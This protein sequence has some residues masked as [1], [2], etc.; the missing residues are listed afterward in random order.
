MKKFN[1]R[2]IL[3]SV[4]S[5]TI[6]ATTIPTSNVYAS[7]LNI[8]EG[9]FNLNA[10]VI[11]E[12]SLAGRADIELDWSDYSFDV[13]GDTV[14]T[15][16]YVARRPVY[17]Q[18][19]STNVK[20][21]GKWEIRGK[22]G[23]QVSVLNIYPDKA[24]SAG[25]K[26]WM[27]TQ[28]ANE[29]VD[30][31]VTT[32]SLTDFNNNPY[33]Y[34]KKNSN[35]SY[36]FDVIVFG[37][38]DSN[39]KVKITSNSSNIIQDFIDAGYG[40]VFG[41]DTIQHTTINLG[42]NNLVQNNLDLIITK[43]D[44]SRWFY[45][46]KI[47]VRKQGSIT[48]YPFDIN[49]RDLK[50]PM[51]HSVGQ[52]PGNTSTGVPNNDEIYMTFEPNYY[53][54]T[55]DGPYFNYNVN[56]GAKGPSPMVS[57]RHNSNPT[58]N[59][60]GSAYL[61]KTNNVAFI[62]C[63]HS[64]G[65]TSNAEQM[66][67]ANLI[68]SIA[69]I[70]HGESSASDQVL[71]DVA[72]TNPSLNTDYTFSSEDSG[73]GFEYRIIAFPQGYDLSKVDKNALQTALSSNVTK[74]NDNVVFSN[75]YTTGELVSKIKGS[76][77][78]ENEKDIASFRYYVDKNSVGARIP[79]VEVDG[80]EDTTDDFYSLKINDKFDYTKH[81]NKIG[82]ITEDDW[83]H[84]VA[85]DRA[86]NASTITDIRVLDAIPK[87]NAYAK[88]VDKQGNIISPGSV[89][90]D[91]DNNGTIE[92]P[93]SENSEQYVGSSFSLK[94]ISNFTYNGD[95]YIYSHSKN[96]E[97]LEINPVIISL[98]VD[99]SKNTVTH[100]YD[101]KL[102]KDIYLVDDRTALANGSKTAYLYTSVT[103]KE[104]ETLDINS[105]KPDLTNAHYTYN[106]WST[107]TG[108]GAIQN[109]PSASSE[110][111]MSSDV[112]NIYIYYKKNTATLNVNVVRDKDGIDGGDT[113][114]LG[115]Y[116]LTGFVGDTLTVT[117]SD[118]R[119]NVAVDLLNC[120]SNN[121]DL[122]TYNK[123]FV[124]DDESGKSDTITLMPRIKDVVYYGIDFENYTLPITTSSSAVNITSDKIINIPKLYETK[125]T[126]DPSKPEHSNG[127][128]VYTAEATYSYDN[129]VW[130]NLVT[131]GASTQSITVNFAN[132]NKVNVGYFKGIRPLA[133]Y[134]ITTKYY[135]VIDNKE[136]H[137]STKSQ[138][139][140]ISD[141]NADISDIVDIF[142]INGIKYD[143]D[144][145]S[146][147]D[148]NRAV[149]F[150][151][152]HYKVLFNGSV[153]KDNI[154][155]I[156]ELSI[157]IPASGAGAYTVE[158]YYRP[159]T[160]VSCT[161][162]VYGYDRTT[163]ISTQNVIFNQL[164]DN[165]E[166]SIPLKTDDEYT[167]D[168]TGGKYNNG[169]V[170]ATANAYD[171]SL[172]ANY[173]PLVYDL[174]VNVINDSKVGTTRD[175]LAYTF[176]NV[177]AKAVTSFKLPIVSGFEF[178]ESKTLNGTD[179]SYLQTD[180]ETVT[181]DP[182]ETEITST[183]TYEIELH[184]GQNAALDLTYVAF[185]KDGRV[186][187]AKPTD[188]THYV[189][190]TVTVNIPE[191][192]NL[193]LQLAYLDGKKYF[194]VAT[195][196]NYNVEITKPSHQLY[197]VYNEKKYT[198]TVENVTGDET[199]YVVGGGEFYK[200]ETAVI[201]A[202]PATGYKFVGWTISP[203]SATIPSL[204][205]IGE[206]SLVMPMENVVAKA[207]FILDTTTDP[208]DNVEPDTSN[209]EIVQPEKPVEPI[210]PIEPVVPTFPE[211]PE[212]PTKPV[213]PSIDDIADLVNDPYYKLIR[214]YSVYVHGYPDGTIQPSESIKRV[215]V[216]AVI[217][218]L[219]GN[220]YVSD[221]KSLERF[222]DVESGT[223]YS[224]AVGFCAD[225]G[226]V[227]GYSDGTIKPN[228]PIS[229]AELAAI[230]AKFVIAKN[231]SAASPSFTDVKA[232]WVKSSIDTLYKNGIIAGY[233]DGTF[234]PNAETKRSEFVVMLN[235]LIKRPTE[236]KQ[237]KTFPDL[238]K[239][240]W[241][242]DDMMNASNGAVVSAD[243]PDYILEN[244]KK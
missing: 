3:A 91:N 107:D 165:K 76:M 230:I 34:L 229:R 41:H 115:T 138:T 187:K 191:V 219:Y 128:G 204:T 163:V 44:K 150:E 194:D 67:L 7:S 43:S 226:V 108:V 177:P 143:I 132:Q 201:S 141:T 240:H 199:G 88:F 239:T 200:G 110:Y 27:T 24:E 49:G 125:V 162:N 118:I 79:P 218:N 101:K 98:N 50:I 31:V 214:E 184:Y 85:Y 167:I 13:N 47:S 215:E 153:V 124:L 45:S 15:D 51:S 16:Y 169:V 75:S 197:L 180:N 168:V 14:S 54:N 234:K 176:K 89:N 65:S 182:N 181:F 139:L 21:Y 97:G 69:Q 4:L 25:L 170:T 78:Y 20:N 30:I 33:K 42:F 63:G 207:S 119:N 87:V 158:V 147:T 93:A 56:G 152:D 77:G 242:Y 86:N 10:P 211:K 203:N 127:K 29:N 23:K 166:H 36:N 237:E 155:T 137:Q 57:Y 193:D 216:M 228:E 37:F 121:I 59:Y 243:L 104:G 84:I 157:Y 133:R 52:L 198:L 82:D 174:V 236:Y 11:T 130:K 26:N 196:Q 129:S 241:A 123:D 12:S 106:G 149:D 74:Y 117:G 114:S 116:T 58:Y 222:K 6:V 5:F 224:Q 2:K 142:D 28:S 144:G 136:I 100:V 221:E 9:A 39:N 135:N 172:T 131:D 61:V 126:F 210:K 145:N 72:P 238:P 46:E 18:D 94:A 223:W 159:Y 81:F 83:L 113:V 213:N 205:T 1:F 40:V 232:N 17:Y 225:F 164:F 171:I 122:I 62:Q 134:D 185:T 19:N 233:Q 55:N 178:I 220:G 212:P 244:I 70:V 66:L 73:V 173:R 120:Y 189:G 227:N 202:T 161:K 156:D 35:G 64:S 96:S 71:D 68:Y 146:I 183:K 208:D 111:T 231:E 140:D 80:T 209:P 148:T 38:W 217:Y 90:G 192:E 105:I 92:Y 22:Y 151:I 112:N 109:I 195:S 8:N 60:V 99:E 95:E 102:T 32:Q 206:Q 190:E 179:T 235:R 160:Q 103:L 53:P 186:E 154:T 188:N 175:Y 48:T